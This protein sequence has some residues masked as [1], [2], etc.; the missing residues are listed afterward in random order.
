MDDYWIREDKIN[1][2]IRCMLDKG[3][4]DESTE[5][6][7]RRTLERMSDEWLDDYFDKV[8]GR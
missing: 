3:L 7:F 1:N 8:K 2:I 5:D 6:T 4:I